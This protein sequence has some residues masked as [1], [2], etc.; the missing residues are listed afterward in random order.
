M[1]AVATTPPPGTAAQVKA[2]VAASTSITKMTA[3]LAAELPGASNDTAD[4]MYNLPHT[5]LTATACQFG[6]TSSDKV[7]ALYGDSHARMWLPALVPLATA[8]GFRLVLVGQDGCPAVALVIYNA[9]GGSAAC[10][11]LRTAAVKLINSMDPEAVIVSDSTTA[12]LAGPNKRFTTAQ[13]DKGLTTTLKAF[14]G[15]PRLVVIGDIQ[16]LDE[17]PTSCL[18]AYP[19]AIQSKCAVDNPNKK[20]K[21]QETA[22]H[23]AATSAHAAYVDPT[24]W[25]CTQKRCSPVIG[26]FIAY[27]NSW[28]VSAMYAAYLSGVMGTAVKPDL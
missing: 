28:H 7:V 13:W 24:S 9:I 19:K 2:L 17:D 6:D 11:V 3:T 21:G 15:S 12:Y 16:V 5:C 8:D 18:A 14:T 10:T 27:W 1:P 20:Y 23:D 25:L 26:T 4:A 22:E